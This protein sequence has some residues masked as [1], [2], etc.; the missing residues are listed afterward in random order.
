VLKGTYVVPY[1]T[2]SMMIH[3][4]MRMKLYMG[5]SERPFINEMIYG[6]E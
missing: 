5:M 3:D 6:I 1:T 2:F 4:W